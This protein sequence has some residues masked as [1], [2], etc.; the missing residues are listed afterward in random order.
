M[1]TYGGF[2]PLRAARLAGF[3]YLLVIIFGGIAAIGVRQRLYVSNDPA[4]TAANILGHE[5]LFR[6]GFASDV[7][8]GIF[9][10]PL[11][12]LLYELLKVVNRRV[13]LAA[14]CFS[15]V[16]CAVQSAALLGHFAP[17]IFLKRGA[18]FGVDPALLRALAYM[19]LQLQGVGYG[20]ALT[21]FGGTMLM[22]GYLIVKSTFLP[23]FI[24]VLLGIE[25]VAYFANSLVD[26]LAPGYAN[27]VLAILMLTA[28]AE[29]ILCLWLLVRGVNVE[30]W[31]AVTSERIKI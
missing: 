21:F 27:T 19:S 8:N 20:I 30:K 22:R 13:A 10:I 17:V 1:E 16:G 18:D 11:I 29:V 23:K 5:Q 14:L 15:L 26:F 3:L 9:V 28:L 12:V 4:A 7:M 6:I 25:G 24:G 2:W 31:R